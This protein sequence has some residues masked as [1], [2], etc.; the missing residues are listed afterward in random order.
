M[1][2]TLVWH[3]GMR[4]PW[5]WKVGPSFDSERSHL[6]A[7]LDEQT[8]PKDTLF[9]AD[10]GFYGYD[11][12][13]SILNHGHQFL[14]RVGSNVRLLKNL[15]EVRQR[16]DIVFCWPDATRKKKQPP[17]VLRLFHF[18]DGRGDVYL[19]SS[20]LD[21]KQLTSGQASDIYRSRWGIE[22]QFRSLKQ[23]FGR[24]KLR[25]RT[26]EHAEIELHWSLLGL[27]MLQLL[28]F[29]EQTTVGEPVPKTSIAGVLR[30][31]RSMIAEQSE[32]REACESLQERLSGATIDSYQR[33]TK[34]KSR[35]YP[36]RKEEPSAGAPIITPAG[37]EHLTAL[38]QLEDYVMAA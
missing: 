2:L 26:P 24:S 4:L 8:F 38:R 15:G 13:Q 23:T 22:L 33:H 29:S 21:D 27:Q 19:V 35:N 5:C 18:H 11:F 17:L 3:I 10:A 32:P 31:V 16:D 30:I 36:R 25:S 20:V 6:L 7:L 9:C 34:K 28:A 1:W 37:E 14:I 12:W